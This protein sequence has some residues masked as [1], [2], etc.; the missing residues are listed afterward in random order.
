MLNNVIL[1]FPMINSLLLYYSVKYQIF[2]FIIMLNKQIKKTQKTLYLLMCDEIYPK[3]ADNKSIYAHFRQ[4][5]YLN[6]LFTKVQIC[7]WM[8]G[9]S[10]A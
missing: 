1:D 5:L 6:S 4:F 9:S 7:Q 3:F 8:N 10:G 2:Y